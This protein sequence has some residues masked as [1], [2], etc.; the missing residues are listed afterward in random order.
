M[1]HKEFEELI[2]KYCF[3]RLPAKKKREFEEH[4]IGCNK[5]YEKL[6]LQEVIV[7]DLKLYGVEGISK[8]AEEALEDIKKAEKKTEIKIPRPPLHFVRSERTVATNGLRR[9]VL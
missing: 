8:K 2:S 1:N 3:N 4:F 7:D 9:T 5:C 6:L